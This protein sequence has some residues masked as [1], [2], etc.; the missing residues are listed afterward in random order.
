[1]MRDPDEFD[2]RR[3]AKPEHRPEPPAPVNM[4]EQTMRQLDHERAGDEPGR[5]RRWLARY[6]GDFHSA[7][8]I[9]ADEGLDASV[10]RAGIEQAAGCPLAEIRAH[11]GIPD[12]LQPRQRLAIVR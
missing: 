2:G 7:E 12:A 4:L 9:A 11:S 5:R 10:V 1:M 8:R 6:R 3:K